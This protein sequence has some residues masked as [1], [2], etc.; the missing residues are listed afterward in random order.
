[1]VLTDTAIALSAK[2]TEFTRMAN[3]Q[4]LTPDGFQR[5]NRISGEHTKHFIQLN[6]N[7]ER[8]V[9]SHYTWPLRKS[10]WI[11][12]LPGNFFELE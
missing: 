3:W 6:I 11:M 9:I 1:M 7:E 8:F 2:C 4:M 12:D 5:G 10:E